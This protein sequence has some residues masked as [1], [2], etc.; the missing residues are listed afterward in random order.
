MPEGPRIHDLTAL[1]ETH[2]P[3]WATSPSPVFEP[4]A[5]IARD[6]YSIERVDCLSHT[7]THVD[8]P[9]HFLEDGATVDAIPPSALVGRAAVLD[10]REDLAGPIVDEATVRAHWPH[11]PVEI[12]LLE[13]GWSRRRAATREYLYDF[14]GLSPAAAQ[15]VAEQ[16]VKGVGTDTLSIDPF[17]NSEYAAH[18]VLL[19]RGIWL[20]EAL[21]HLDALRE[22][23]VY[24]LVVAPLKIAHGS[25]AMARVFALESPEANA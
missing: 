6:G 18:K 14:P 25:G 11:A 21:D 7:G 23:T 19:R 8:A 24:T 16:G 2:M 3:T 22:G 15:F 13:T 17:A 20:V 4:T 9:Y 5:I 12:V 1:L 10:V